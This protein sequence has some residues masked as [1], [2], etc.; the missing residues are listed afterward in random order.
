MASVTH[1][2]HPSCS[3]GCRVAVGRNRQLLWGGGEVSV[4]PVPLLWRGVAVLAV[5]SSLG[6]G[7]WC[8]TCSS[9]VEGGCCSCCSVFWGGGVVLNVPILWRW[10]AVLL[11]CLQGGGEIGVLTVPLLWRGVAVLAVL[12]SVGERGWCS[13]CSSFMEVRCCSCCSVFC[14]GERWVF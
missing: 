4:L 7:G 11:F 9:S 5:L 10:V 14:G 1:P 8:S 13:N 12:S 3:L 6:E 2:T